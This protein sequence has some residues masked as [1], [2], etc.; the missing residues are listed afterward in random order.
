M[1]R[2]A[3]LEKLL[4]GVPRVT[5]YRRMRRPLPF[6]LATNVLLAVLTMVT[7]GLIFW[8]MPGS[9][10]MIGPRERLARSLAAH[11]RL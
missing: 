2:L 4:L 7:V 6:V 3:D 11:L 10:P 9:R 5:G 8:R 1:V